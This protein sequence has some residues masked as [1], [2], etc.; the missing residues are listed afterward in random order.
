MKKRIGL[1]IVSMLLLILTGCSDVDSTSKESTEEKI[2][3]FIIMEV[4]TIGSSN[5]RLHA[6]V[7]FNGIVETVLIKGIAIDPTLTEIKGHILV[8]KVENSNIEAIE[9]K[10]N[11]VK[12]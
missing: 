5:T 9:I 11:E 12:E 4:A 7:N 1:L 6:V 3:E 8:G 2:E 10:K